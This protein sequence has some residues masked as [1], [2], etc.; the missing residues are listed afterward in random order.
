MTQ[1]SPCQLFTQLPFNVLKRTVLPVPS[2]VETA[3]TM[4][5]SG[6]ATEITSSLARQLVSKTSN[7][8]GGIVRQGWSR[9][10][11]NP[12]VK[13]VDPPRVE[14]IVQH[15]EGESLSYA[16]IKSM[17]KLATKIWLNFLLEV[18]VI[19]LKAIN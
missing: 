14:V 10:Y 2:S 7:T 6:V 8:L 1:V 18:I 3:I 15:C 12:P 9:L 19:T 13:Q 11:R 16:M 4:T 5:V 17:V